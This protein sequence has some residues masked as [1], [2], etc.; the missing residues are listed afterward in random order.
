M[1]AGKEEVVILN[2][3]GDK[4]PSKS[5]SR[6]QRGKTPTI[7]M[8]PKVDDKPATHASVIADAVA[9]TQGRVAGRWGV[10]TSG[11]A[12]TVG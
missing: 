1:R 5:R 12:G 11:R 7:P 9:S 6:S 8:G 2:V 4:A 3:P 10:R